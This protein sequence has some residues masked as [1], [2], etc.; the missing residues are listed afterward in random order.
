MSRYPPY[1]LWVPHRQNLTGVLPADHRGGLQPRPPRH[2]TGRW[3]VWPAFGDG[4]PEKVRPTGAPADPYDQS[5]PAANP[6]RCRA[7]TG[8]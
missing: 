2:G 3:A 6:G 4:P 1:H 5:A 8:T 7:T